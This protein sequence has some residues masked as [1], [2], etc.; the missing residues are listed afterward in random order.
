MQENSKEAA[1]KR[2]WK[3]DAQENKEN[4]ARKQIIIKWKIQLAWKQEGQYSE[5]KG[6]AKN[7]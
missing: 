1:W 6:Q 2:V 4:K 5:N 3:S 7:W